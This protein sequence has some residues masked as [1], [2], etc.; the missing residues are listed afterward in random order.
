MCIRIMYFCS[1]ADESK[2][3]F[4]KSERAGGPAELG[5]VR[6]HAVHVTRHH[7]S[8]GQVLTL[9]SCGAAGRLPRRSSGGRQRI[10]QAAAFRLSEPQR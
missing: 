2:L 1:V 5:N 9:K 8:P 6:N 3:V 4:V 7:Q 10:T